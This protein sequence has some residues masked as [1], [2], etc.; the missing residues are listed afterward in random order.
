[1]SIRI[2]ERFQE[3]QLFKALSGVK[4]YN[5][6]VGF[7]LKWLGLSQV[8][9]DE[10]H[11]VHYVKK[12]DLLRLKRSL[13][14]VPTLNRK[15]LIS[16]LI[17]FKKA[18]LHFPQYLTDQDRKAI[19]KCVRKHLEEFRN[20]KL[21][22]QVTNFKKPFPFSLHIHQS[23]KN[24]VKESVVIEIPGHKPFNLLK[25]EE[26]S[27][28]LHWPDKKVLGVSQKG[29]DRLKGFVKSLK[30]EMLDDSVKIERTEQDLPLSLLLVPNKSGKLSQIIL[31]PKKAKTGV[32]GKGRFKEVKHAYDLTRGMRLVKK[33]MKRPERNLF[34]KLQGQK[35]IQE[36]VA[37][38]KKSVDGEERFT[39]FEALCD[40]T[41]YQLIRTT[42]TN[43]HKKEIIKSLLESLA[44]FHEQTDDDGVPF[45]HGDIKTQNIL[46][47]KNLQGRYEV[48]LTDFG[49]S[50]RK[51]GFA[52]T[53]GWVSP[54][55]AK[56]WLLAKEGIK[57][58]PKA[59]GQALDVWG[60][61]LVIACLLG[62]RKSFQMLRS[63]SGTKR[64]LEKARD[65]KQNWVDREIKS[66]SKRSDR[67]LKPIWNV[68]R[69]MLA[70]DLEARL[71]SSQALT[72]LE[73]YF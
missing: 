55:H 27:L 8:I 70:V 15:V 21:H 67:Q 65:V 35:G 52:G 56:G 13:F 47:K 63:A 22:S 41:L 23:R 25:N 16:D 71:T 36:I 24:L 45:F 30:E 48:F 7:F 18:E 33:L 53:P 57:N 59:Q 43:D 61:G 10:N 44:N 19:E 46:Y 69:G 39:L 17:R 31:L 40:G 34:K 9:L 32:V 12:K 3:Y 14:E 5:Q 60:M 42:L 68:V 50:N 66:L 73:E 1:M 72:L 51:R 11:K 20:T 6:L 28:V 29:M 37:E 58:G 62:G 49:L 54:E 26:K 2:K 4:E 38:R 64:Y